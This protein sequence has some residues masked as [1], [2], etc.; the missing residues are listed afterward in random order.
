MSLVHS[1]ASVWTDGLDRHVDRTLM[2]AQAHPVRTVGDAR[3]SSTVMH[4]CAR[5]LA[6]RETAAR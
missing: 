6:S 4:A 2:T 3:I 5:V 1:L